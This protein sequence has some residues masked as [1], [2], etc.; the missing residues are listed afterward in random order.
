MT[1]DLT[2]EPRGVMEEVLRY[3]VVVTAVEPFMCTCQV[4]FIVI[5]HL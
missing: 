2:Q 3:F 5:M 1:Q 4:V